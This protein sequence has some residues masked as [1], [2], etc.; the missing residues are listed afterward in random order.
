MDWPAVKQKAVCFNLV[1]N[2]KRLAILAGLSEQP[3][4]ILALGSYLNLMTK[5]T[6]PLPTVRNLACELK[7]AGI[8]DCEQQRRTVVYFLTDSGQFLAEV[9]RS[10]HLV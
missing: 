1:G 7:N 5:Q 8:V 3:M 4:D 6:I 9:I 2:P 10:Q